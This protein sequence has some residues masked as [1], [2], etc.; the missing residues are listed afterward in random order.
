MDDLKML[1]TALAGPEPSADV[2]D[3]SRHRL[4]N[5]MRG[6]SAERGRRKRW[7]AAGVGLTAAAAAGAVVVSDPSAPE[8]KKEPVLSGRQVMLAAATTAAAKP[9]ATGTYWHTKLVLT[10]GKVTHVTETWTRR[11]GATWL[12]GAPG[13]VSRVAKRP[14]MSGS[15]LDFAGVQRL[16]T[17]PDRLK[18]GLLKSARYPA[19]RENPQLWTIN[20]LQSVLSEAPAPPQ[21]RAA[22]YRALAALPHIDNLG[23]TAGGYRLKISFMNDSGTHVD[24]TETIVVDPKSTRLRV[25][26]WGGFGGGPNPFGPSQTTSGWTDTLPGRIV[27]WS[28]QKPYIEKENQQLKAQNH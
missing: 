6:G 25:E 10:M 13:L 5:A 7:I 20:L 11:D 23:R 9:A 22:A 4:Q 16:P 17:D 8:A 21:V 24:G 12:S 27:P 26:G 15:D 19:A 18:A 28:S 1:G 3:R 14:V 2:V